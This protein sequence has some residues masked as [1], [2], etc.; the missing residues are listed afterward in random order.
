MTLVPR[1]SGTVLTIALAALVAMPG[2]A[3]TRR[4][5]VNPNP[6]PAGA[7][8]PINGI[9]VDE[10]N[11]VPVEA[12]VVT[13]GGRTATTGTNGRF[14]ITIPVG[15]PATIAISHPAFAAF[16]QSITA[17]S[18][19]TYTFK[20]T[21]RPSVTIKLNNGDT[22]VVDIGT[23]Q[24]A[25]QVGFGSAVRSDN[26]NLCRNNEAFTPNKSEF[27]KILGPTTSTTIPACCQ[28]GPLLGATVQLKSGASETM[29]FKD[30]CAGIDVSFVGREKA[31][32]KYTYFR[33][34]DIAEIDFP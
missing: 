3:Q 34:A 1:I 11:D 12:A 4:R 24:F 26:A 28:F 5:A 6:S 30:S 9:V 10:S 21:E 32:A 25:Y 7:T 14:T 27:S 22:H 15:T 20:L 31:N 2:A 33:F 23:A 13:A 16:S 18:G 29:Y 8:G 19:G 17:Q